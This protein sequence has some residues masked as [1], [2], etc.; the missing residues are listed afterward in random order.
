MSPRV[1]EDS[2]HPRLSSCACAR[3]LNFTV[4]RPARKAMPDPYFIALLEA[5]V[6]SVLGAAATLGATFLLQYRR[7]LTLAW[8]MWLWGTVG[9]IICNVA[10]LV[11]FFYLA[12]LGG[13]A[14]GTLRP[15]D[16]GH[17]LIYVLIGFGPPIFSGLGA[18][19]GCMYG[20]R[21]AK[22]RAPAV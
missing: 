22:R 19:L 3:P 11:L 7:F 16:P 2:V 18:I 8:R 21:L 1:R 17:F 10:L 14:G 15:L 20:W 4:R 6:F 12:S 13:I 9:L 5:V